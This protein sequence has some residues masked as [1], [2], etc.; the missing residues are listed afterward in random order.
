M[1]ARVVLDCSVTVS[2][3]FEDESNETSSAVRDSLASGAEAVVPAHWSLEVSNALLTAERRGR[4]LRA[5][6]THFLGL[7]TRLPITTDPETSSLAFGAIVHLAR[8]HALTPYDAAYLELAL[9]VGAPLAT[10]DQQ[11]AAAAKA[12][13]VRVMDVNSP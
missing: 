2:W 12:R 13:G 10:F 8:E 1:V 9:R 6:S 7:L 3:C 11:L 4:L 5:Q